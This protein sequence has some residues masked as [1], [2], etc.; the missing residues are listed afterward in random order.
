MLKI[1]FFSKLACYV[2]WTGTVLLEPIALF[3]F[4]S[5][6]IQFSITSTES[7]TVVSKNFTLILLSVVL[8]KI[9]Y[10]YYKHYSDSKELGSS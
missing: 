4:L 2:M 7:G 10:F 6:K 8:S 9:Y 1:F 3:W 5:V